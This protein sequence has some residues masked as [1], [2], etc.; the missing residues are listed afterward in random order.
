MPNQTSKGS[1][2]SSLP[3]EETESVSNLVMSTQS[4]TKTISSKEHL[5]VSNASRSCHRSIK[6]SSSLRGLNANFIRT[7]PI[8]S[9]VE[10]NC[11][12]AVTRWNATYG[13]EFLK[14][15]GDMVDNGNAAIRVH[16]LFRSMQSLVGFSFPFCGYEK[17]T[18]VAAD[19]RLVVRQQTLHFANMLIVTILGKHY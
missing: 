7:I 2:Q 15:L 14:F 18:W 5:K 10:N 12:V 3:G 6:R 9:L 8:N 11:D 19:V 4:K 16:V 13:F 17:Q 1:E